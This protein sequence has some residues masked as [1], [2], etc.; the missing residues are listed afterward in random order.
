MDGIAK[1]YVCNSS[2]MNHIPQVFRLLSDPGI[3]VVM[4][5]LGLLRNLLSNDKQHIDHISSLY[6]KQLMH[7]VVF[8]LESE[9]SPEVRSK[10]LSSF[11]PLKG[12][13][14]FPYN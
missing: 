1:Y 10:L 4:K 14:H 2:F 7:A 8:I 5:T 11:L 12:F 3:Q 13:L 6:G 9:N